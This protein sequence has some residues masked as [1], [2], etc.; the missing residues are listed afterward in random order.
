MGRYQELNDFYWQERAEFVL[1][2]QE[3]QRLAL[4]LVGAIRD[5]WET[6]VDAVRIIPLDGEPA[7]DAEYDIAEEMVV[8]EGWFHFRFEIDLRQDGRHLAIAFRFALDRREEAWAVDTDNPQ[9]DAFILHDGRPEDRDRFLDE[10]YADLRQFL[11]NAAWH[12]A[13]DQRRIGFHQP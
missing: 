2:V 11:E 6:P 8:L 13:R 4:E 5:R 9:A 12:K 1:T 10:L 7:P 3:A